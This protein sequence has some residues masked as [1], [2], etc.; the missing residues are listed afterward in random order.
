MSFKRFVVNNRLLKEG[1]ERLALSMTVLNQTDRLEKMIKNEIEATPEQIDDLSKQLRSNMQTAWKNNMLSKDEVDNIQSLFSK[2]KEI[3]TSKDTELVELNKLKDKFD[4]ITQGSITD[5]SDEEVQK[6]IDRYNNLIKSLVSRK[7]INEEQKKQ[8]ESFVTEFIQ[9]NKQF[10]SSADRYLL[11]DNTM[12][13][14]TDNVFKTFL[15]NGINLSKSELFINKQTTNVKNIE[16]GITLAIQPNT[17]WSQSSKDE[18]TFKLYTYNGLTQNEKNF[19]DSENE[20]TVDKKTFAKIRLKNMNQILKNSTQTKFSKAVRNIKKFMD[21]VKQTSKENIPEEGKESLASNPFSTLFMVSE[22]NNQIMDIYGNKLSIPQFAV[23]VE[24]EESL[25]KQGTDHNITLMDFT[26]P[27]KNVKSITISEE[28]FAL[29]ERNSTKLDTTNE[30]SLSKSLKKSFV[31]SAINFIQKIH[32]TPVET[33]QRSVG[34]KTEFRSPIPWS[35]IWGGISKAVSKLGK[36]AAAE[37]YQNKEPNKQTG[38][39]FT[40]ETV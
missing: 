34:N 31:G 28:D 16:S 20:Y 33:W 39:I 29:L 32:M 9:S 26:K 25:S 7:L 18:I 21:V 35:E 37:Q 38:T 24:T 4:G 3:I 11:D 17:V 14:I 27:E 23:I 10:K 13:L 5:V 1:N 15:K 2:S 6:D 36:S 40:R 12:L 22:E 19:I 30:T 8:Y